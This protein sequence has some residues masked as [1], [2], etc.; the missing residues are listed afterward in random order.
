MDSDVMSKHRDRHDKRDELAPVAR[1]SAFDSRSSQS[2]NPRVRKHARDEVL[3]Q[4]GIREAAFFL[5]GQVREALHQDGREQP[6]SGSRRGSMSVVD[7]DPVSDNSRRVSVSA[8]MV[9]WSRLPFVGNRS[10]INTMAFRDRPSAAGA[11]GL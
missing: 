7:L 3:A 1:G 5:D 4:A 10:W 2:S 8:A 6:A 9:S 11:F